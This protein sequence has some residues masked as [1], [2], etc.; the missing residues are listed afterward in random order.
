MILTT[1][2]YFDMHCDTLS[3]AYANKRQDLCEFPEAMVDVR[4]LRK[5]G[6][7]A[8]FFAMFMWD[9]GLRE[10]LGKDFPEDH[11]YI[12]ALLEIMQNTIARCPGE[13]ALAK[14]A[15]DLRKNAEAGKLSAVLTVEDGRGADGKL[16][17]LQAWYDRGVR[18]ITLT[19]NH[20]NCMGFPHAEDPEEM[21]R[22]LTPFGR[23]AVALMNDLGMLVDVSH[24]SDGGFRDVAEISRKPF[25][26]SHS[27][28]RAVTPHT[29]NLTDEMIRT[30]ADH[31]G[32][33]GLNFCPRFLESGKKPAASLEAMIAH[34]RHLVNVGGIDCAALGSDL[35]GIEGKLE[36][37]SC[38]RMPML[39]EA[40]GKAGFTE[41]E[42]QRIAWKN[43]RR[44]MEDVLR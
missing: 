35:D 8:Q 43:A 34:L 20:A 36:I 18:L 17:N 37:G 21:R 15:A 40:L 5:G 26:A 11:A 31:G 19:W 38:D 3:R 41:D 29:R 24:L 12:Q 42:I 6:C 44:V 23:D 28:C 10:K 9:I 7:Q 16:E 4:R 1:I 32:V 30:L 27:N 13:L 25:V 22:G 2:P 33:A 14:N 39:F